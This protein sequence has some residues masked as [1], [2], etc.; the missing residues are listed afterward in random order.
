VP[1][2]ACS[3]LANGQRAP[4]FP[5]GLT[6]EPVEFFFTFEDR[7]EREAGLICRERGPNREHCGEECHGKQAEMVHGKKSQPAANTSAP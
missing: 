1:T 3:P 5:N 7:G 6:D 2:N 4:I